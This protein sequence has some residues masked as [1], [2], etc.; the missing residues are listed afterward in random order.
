[1]L[2]C[3]NQAEKIYG[4][5]IVVL[6]FNTTWINPDTVVIIYIDVSREIINN[7]NNTTMSGDILFVYK[8]NFF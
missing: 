8:I 3:V 2:K 1:M 6:K 7:N 4:L 5:K